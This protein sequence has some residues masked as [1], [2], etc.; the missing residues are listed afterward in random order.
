[1]LLNRK[2]EM[3]MQDFVAAYR[4]TF[5][6]FP[7]Y[8]VWSGDGVVRTSAMQSYIYPNLA[9]LLNLFLICEHPS[10]AAFYDYQEIKRVADLGFAFPDPKSAK[11]YLEHENKV[12]SSRKEMADLVKFGV[13]LKVLVTYQHG[14]VEQQLLVLN[15][16]YSLVLGSNENHLSEFLVVLP[17]RQ[18]G[19]LNGLVTGKGWVTEELWRFYGWDAT[20]NQFKYMDI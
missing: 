6:D 16:F 13:G 11:L 8:A 17:G 1:M 5:N 18:Q 19:D 9:D 15:D 3:K 7:K 12:G 4:A 2:I 10:D 14:A 20:S